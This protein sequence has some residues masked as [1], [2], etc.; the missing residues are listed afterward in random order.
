MRGVGQ[1]V[2][3]SPIQVDQQVAV[4]RVNL[5]LEELLELAA[6]AKVD[7]LIDGISITNRDIQFTQR[8]EQDL[9]EI[10]DALADI[11]Y[12]TH[13]AAHAWGI[14]SQKVFDEVQNSNLSKLPDGFKRADG[15]WMKGPNYRPADIAS[16]IVGREY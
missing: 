13:G 10:A 14:P 9:V 11:E 12:V 6:A 1:E 16:I 8:G 2:N 7:I 5:I 3:T 15:K 4:L